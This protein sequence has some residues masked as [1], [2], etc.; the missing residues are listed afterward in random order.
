MLEQALEERKNLDAK[1]AKAKQAML[2]RITEQM[3][4]VI[5]AENALRYG[6]RVTKRNPWAGDRAAAIQQIN[7]SGNAAI[8]T[9]NAYRDMWGGEVRALLQAGRTR[10]MRALH[11]LYDQIDEQPCNPDSPFPGGHAFSGEVFLVGVL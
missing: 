8:A 7:A 10:A 2:D 3:Q 11:D 1:L 4:F 6:D 5:E 9:C